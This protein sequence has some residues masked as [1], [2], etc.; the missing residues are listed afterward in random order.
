MKRYSVQPR[1]RI[2]VKGYGFLSFAKNIGKNI[3]KNISENLNVKH[4]QKLFDHA[5]QF[6]TDAIKTSSK[7]VIQKTAK[8]I[9]DVIGNKNPN[10]VAKS[11]NGRIT[12]VSGSSPQNNSE[13]IANEHDKEIPKD[14]YIST[15][16]RQK[17]IVNL[18][19]M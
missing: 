16:K 14:R 6:A 12:K 13:T 10:A 4:S 11:Y 9:G 15:E 1:D 17:I 8:A 7:R 2:F 3:G 19:L 5:K 18:R